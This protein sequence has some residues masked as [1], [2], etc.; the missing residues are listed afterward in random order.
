M[1]HAIDETDER[2]GDA[3]ELVFDHSF[4][5]EIDPGYDINKLGTGKDA[6]VLFTVVDKEALVINKMAYPEEVTRIPLGFYSEF[7]GRPYRI[8]PIEMPSGWN[9]YLEDRL[10]K[11]WH[12]LNA[13]AYK[14][15]ND[16][17]TSMNRFVMHFSMIYEP[18]DPAGPA[19][20]AWSTDEGIEIRFDHIK[21]SKAEIILTNISGQTLFLDVKASTDNN[22]IIPLEDA[23]EQ[24]YVVTVKSKDITSSTKVVR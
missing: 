19:I 4:T 22:Y 21:S 1:L 17:E 5:N 24:F 20:Y 9:V 18:V 10:T 8:E 12:D 15:V 16:S 14:F 2:L 23:F 6:P 3:T 11:E 7:D 13:G